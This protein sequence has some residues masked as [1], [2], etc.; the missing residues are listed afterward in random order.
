MALGAAGACP[1]SPCEFHEY[2]H[3]RNQQ[4]RRRSCPQDER[5][6]GHRREQRPEHPS[7]GG[8]LCLENLSAHPA[9]D[10]ETG[11]SAAGFVSDKAHGGICGQERCQA[12]HAGGCC[13]HDQGHASG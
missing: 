1:S 3:E 5:A 8:W 11:G 4:R 7:A 6:D 2:S 9:T 13:F 12:N 10:P